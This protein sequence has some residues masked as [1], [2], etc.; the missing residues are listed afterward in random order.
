M[1][2]TI[3]MRRPRSGMPQ[4]EAIC[5][6]IDITKWFQSAPSIH[7]TS[8]P[9]TDLIQAAKA[10]YRDEH[11]GVARKRK[12]DLP[13]HDIAITRRKSAS[14]HGRDPNN[15]TDASIRGSE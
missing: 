7:Q 14:I 9:N 4:R 11:Q 12:K 6:S 13:S 15:L 8:K 5:W 3:A 2:R 1:R 10:F